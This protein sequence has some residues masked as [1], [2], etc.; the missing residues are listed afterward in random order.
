MTAAHVQK[1]QAEKL[2]AFIAAEA[3]ADLINDE[4]EAVLGVRPY[5]KNSINAPYHPNGEVVFDGAELLAAV[6]RLA[7]EAKR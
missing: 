4:F 2:A 3:A 1:R 5:A 7:V 6:R